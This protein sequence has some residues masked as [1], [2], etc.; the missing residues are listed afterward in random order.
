L[1]AQLS[2]CEVRC[3]KVLSDFTETDVPWRK[4]VISNQPY[5]LSAANSDG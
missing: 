2:D 1:I 3:I 5:L 4:A